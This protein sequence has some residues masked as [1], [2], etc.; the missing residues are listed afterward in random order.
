MKDGLKPQSI[1]RE[2]NI[3]VAMFNKGDTTSSS[4][5]MAAAADAETQDYRRPARKDL[6]RTRDQSHPGRAVRT[7]ARGRTNSGGDCSLSSRPEGSVLS[8]NGLRHSEMNLIPKTGIDWEARQVRIRQGKTGNYKVIGPLGPTSMEILREFYDESK[9]DLVSSHVAAISH[10]S[11]TEFYERLAN[12]LE[13]HM[14][15]ARATD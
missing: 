15:A 7:Q 4:W 14:V 1:D 12:A 5:T 6:E 8:L 3:I 13:Y 2:L 11:F 9:T 10:Q